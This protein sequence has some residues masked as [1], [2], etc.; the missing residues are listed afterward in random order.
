MNH[1]SM[2]T[3]TLAVALATLGCNDANSS[4]SPKGSADRKVAEAQVKIN[5]ANTATAAAADAKRDEYAAEMRKQ[6]DA[7]D[8]KTA[9]MKAQAAK[10]EGEAKKDLDKKLA[11]AQV[12]REAAV[13][14]L[15]ELKTA[16]AD[17]WEKIKDGVGS[18]FDEL[19]K[20]FE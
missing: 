17:R 11:A 8:A 6:L 14:R 10:A 18:A 2:F 20:S 19:K 1:A 9:E 4:M 13:A 5:E 16:S 15:E 3:L 7:L 12:R